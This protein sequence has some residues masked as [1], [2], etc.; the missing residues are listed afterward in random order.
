MQYFYMKYLFSIY[1]LVISII[2]IKELLFAFLQFFCLP[3][4]NL[5]VTGMYCHVFFIRERNALLLTVSVKL[6][7]KG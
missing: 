7:S 1:K 3:N 6:L 2:M 4:Y 5:F